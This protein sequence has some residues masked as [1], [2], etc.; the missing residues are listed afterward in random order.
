MSRV[1]FSIAN[2]L[3]NSVKMYFIRVLQYA[4][5]ATA[6]ALTT[7]Y[8]AVISAGSMVLIR[9]LGFGQ[10]SSLSE[11]VAADPSTLIIIATA[12]CCCFSLEAI[13]IQLLQKQTSINK[14]LT[15]RERADD[16]RVT[17]YEI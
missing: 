2:S 16:Q 10:N 5:L 9:F 13:R 1:N 4:I 6:A 12:L 14:R 7:L 11:K 15:D 17:W 3:V 8:F